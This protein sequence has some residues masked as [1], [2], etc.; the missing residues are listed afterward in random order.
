[1]DKQS[2]ESVLEEQMDAYTSHLA[3]DVTF[4]ENVL[5]AGES[6]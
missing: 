5:D 6:C 4:R 3:S 1:M 2:L